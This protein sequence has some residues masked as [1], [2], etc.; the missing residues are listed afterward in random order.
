V[1][2]INAAANPTDRALLLDIS[3]SLLD[4]PANGGKP[5]H[6]TL[7]KRPTGRVSHR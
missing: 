4:R 7:P 6:G 1:A 3:V 5:L 2:V